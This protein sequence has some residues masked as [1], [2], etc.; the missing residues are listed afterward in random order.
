MSI[1]TS[2]DLI[3][4]M[5]KVKQILPFAGFV[6]VIS[7]ECSPL[8]FLKERIQGRIM[9]KGI[10]LSVKLTET[11]I[12]LSIQCGGL[13]AVS[14]PLGL[15]MNMKGSFIMNERAKFLNGLKDHKGRG[16]IDFSRLHI[17]HPLDI[18]ERPVITKADMDATPHRR[19][20]VV[21]KAL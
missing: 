17:K 2:M 7:R 12:L 10:K 15:Q 13:C 5:K 3:M 14:L 9:K 8:L 20:S 11:F 4:M 1:E 18:E 19:D 21:K 6:L 16:L